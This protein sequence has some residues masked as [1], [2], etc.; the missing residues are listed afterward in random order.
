MKSHNALLLYLI[1]LDMSLVRKAKRAAP[2][3]EREVRVLLRRT[4]TLPLEKRWQA[5]LQQRRDR[6]PLP[7]LLEEAERDVNR[8]EASDG[9]TSEED[10]NPLVQDRVLRRKIHH[11]KMA[12]EPG[13]NH[14]SVLERS[15]V[16]E[17]TWAQY[18]KLYRG[19]VDYVDERKLNTDKVQD[20]DVAIVSFMT[21][22]YML[23]YDAGIGQKL[24]AAV[25]FFQPRFGKLGD[26][27]LP[28]AWRAARGWAKLD[29]P[30]SR[31]PLTLPTVAG[32]AAM[33][34]YA[35]HL[36]MG[37]WVII[38][39]CTYLRPGSTMQ[40][41]R[42]SLVPPAMKVD[43][44]WRV[45][46]HRSDLH[47]V[48]KVGAQDDTI[49]WDT[50]GF[51]W[52]GEVLQI[53]AVGARNESLWQFTYPELVREIRKQGRLLGQDI[54]P[55]QLRHAG[56]SWDIY[57]KHRNLCEVQRRGGWMSTKSV[58]RYEKSGMM[59]K[60]Y[61]LLPLALRCW[62]E[63][64]VHALKDSILRGRAVQPPPPLAF[65]ARG[66][67]VATPPNTAK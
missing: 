1:G 2:T 15:S 5:T 12:E 13:M 54:V 23:G 34:A 17:R 48:S 61:A 66:K 11:A 53:L 30:R 58:Q 62:L 27:S 26:L 7:V 59:M 10:G 25:V 9:T 33:L 50:H 37:I 51:E 42:G 45:L 19:L 64:Q 28:R 36:D 67:R 56:A 3:E 38:A 8:L 43:A 40:L 6:L 55:Y 20:V 18:R 57:K 24:I 39:F 32:L 21:H 29:P 4:D 14:V 16:G 47:Q 49:L 22:M 60:D 52:M 63:E 44:M 35:G 46:A 65:S 31:Q 41:S